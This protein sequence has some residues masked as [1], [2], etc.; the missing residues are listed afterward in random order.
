MC[1]I[2]SLHSILL[3]DFN[4][5]LGKEDI[6]KPATGNENLHEINNDNGVRMV[7]FTISKNLTVKS[8]MFPHHRIRKYTWTFPHGKTNILIGHIR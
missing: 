7:N 6:F 8:M 4:A 2:N 3:G 5:K 1:L